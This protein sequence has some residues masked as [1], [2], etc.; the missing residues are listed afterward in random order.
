M[1]LKFKLGDEVV[2]K[3]NEIGIITGYYIA[4][5]IITICY[6]NIDRKIYEHFEKDLMFKNKKHN[7]IKYKFKYKLNEKVLDCFGHIALV[8]RIILKKN[9]INYGLVYGNG[10]IYY[11]E[12]Q[13]I[14]SLDKIYK[15][16]S[17]AEII[18]TEL[19]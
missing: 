14:R 18:W 15:Q 5:E 1:K 3:D 12:H 9:E 2:T 13:I 6:V 11:E 7:Y 19:K 10:I 17:K 4:E 8:K 16:S